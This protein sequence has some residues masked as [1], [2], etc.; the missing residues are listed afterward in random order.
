MCKSKEFPNDS[1]SDKGK[2]YCLGW[3]QVKTLIWK[4][5]LSKFRTPLGT[6]FEIFS[7]LMLI[8]V[9]VVS[10]QL[11]EVSTRAAAKYSSIDIEFPGPWVDLVGAVTD[12]LGENGTADIDF[13]EILGSRRH[14]SQNPIQALQGFSILQ[15]IKPHVQKHRRRLQASNNNVTEDFGAKEDGRD[16]GVFDFLDVAADQIQDV[17]KNPFP[18]PTFDQYVLASQAISSLINPDDLPIILSQSSFGR[19]FGNLLTLGTLHISPDVDIAHEFVEYL[20]KT[21]PSVMNAL[22]V[23]LHDSEESAVSFINDNLNERTW[24]L[25]DF[26]KFQTLEDIEFQIRMNYTTLPNTNR[27]VNYVARGLNTRYRRY[28]LSGYLTLQRTIDEFA[29]SRVGCDDV[30]SNIWSMPMP[31]AKFEQNVFF[32]AVGF[33]LGLTIAMAFLYPTSRTIKMIVEEKES[34]MKETLLILG[35]RPWA[36]WLS[37]F[38]SSNFTYLIS[39]MLVTWALTTSILVNSNAVYLYVFIGFFSTATVGFCFVVAACFSRAKLA[40]I[41]GPMAFFAT[42]LPRFIFFDSNRYEATGGKLLGSLL[43]CTAF[44]FGADIIADYEYAEVGIQSW[45]ASEGEYSFNTA[46]FMLFFDTFLYTFLGWYLD[47]VI[48]RQYGV[49]RP[50]Y[51][52][53]LPSYWCS[54][55]SCGM[56]TRASSNPTIAVKANHGSLSDQTDFEPVT[57]DAL[58]PTVFI[59]SLVKKYSKAANRA[60]DDLTLTLYESQITCLLGHNGAGKT[61]T[62]SILTG[63]FPPTSGDCVVYGNS[64]VR[65]PNSIR[66]SMGICPQHNVLFDRLSVNEHLY[67]FQRIKGANPTS[68]DVT[69]SAVEVGLGEYHKTA[70]MALSGGNKRKLSLAIALSGDPKLLLLDEP[71]SGMDVASRRHCWELL[72]R[73]RKGRVTLLTTH[74]LDEAS[75]LADRIAVMKE[76]KLQCCGSE[77]FLKSRFGLGYN[78]TIVMDSDKFTTVRSRDNVDAVLTFLTA[79]VVGTKLIRESARELTFR[80]P[81]GAEAQFPEMF[82]RLAV[83]SARLGIGSYGISDTTLEEIF[84]QLADHEVSDIVANEATP[85]DDLSQKTEDVHRMLNGQKS[86]EGTSANASSITK[87][88]QSLEISKKT[89]ELNAD[90]EVSNEELQH[91]SPLRQIVLLY[92]KRFLIQRRDVKGFFFS[93]ILPVILCAL[94]LLILIIEIPIVGPPREISMGLYSSSAGTTN[95]LTDVVIGGGVSFDETSTSRMAS[96]EQEFD[97]LS[98]FSDQYPNARIVHLENASS[99]EDLS[100]HL[101]DTYND[102]DHH[103]RYGSFVLFDRINFNIDVNWT[104]L[105][106]E[107]RTLMDL[108]QDSVGWDLFRGFISGVFGVNS[109][110]V[111]DLTDILGDANKSLIDFNISVL[112]DF[113]LSTFD[114]MLFYEKT[115]EVLTSIGQASIPSNPN[116]GTDTVANFRVAIQKFVNEA[117]FVDEGYQ[118][119]Q[120][121][122]AAFINDI[123]LIVTRGVI[124]DIENVT[125]KDIAEILLAQEEIFNRSLIVTGM[126]DIFDVLLAPFGGA[127]VTSKAVVDLVVGALDETVSALLGNNMSSSPNDFLIL[128]IVMLDEL[129]I[130]LV[131]NAEYYGNSSFGYYGNS[132]FGYY[133]NSS[134]L[135]LFN[136]LV[137][138]LS[139]LYLS[140]KVDDITL[141]LQLLSASA[142]GLSLEIAL[143]NF[144]MNARIEN[145]TLNLPSMTLSLSGMFLQMMSEQL[146]EDGN[147]IFELGGSFIES[148]LPAQPITYTVGIDS[149]TSIIHNSSSPHAVA[150]FNQA[151]ME[152]LFKRCTGDPVSSRLVSINNPLPITNEQAIEVQTILSILAGLFLLIPYC[153]IPG[154]FVVFLVKERVSK[155][156]HL[157]LVSG[158]DLTSYWVSTYLWDM[159][160]FAVITGLL[161]LVFF[162]Y[163]SKSAV[164]FVGNAQSAIA[165]AALTFGYGLSILPFSYLLSRMFN[166]HSSAQIAIMA[167]VFICG[168]VAVNGYYIMT[169]IEETQ[170]LAATLLPIFRCFPSFNV[171]E[172]FI[173]LSQAYFERLILGIEKSPLDWDVAGLPLLLL[174]SEPIPYFLILLFLEYSADGGS[175]GFVGRVIRKI[176]T[177]YTNLI[178]SCYGIR[179][180]AEGISLVLEDS[181]DEGRQE[182]EDVTNE[183]S[184]VRENKTELIGKAS[185]LIY[186]MWKVF[187]PSVGFLGRFIGRICD[188]LCCRCFGK[189]RNKSDDDEIDKSNFPK[190]AVRGVCTAVMPG[191]TYGLLGVNGAGKTTTLGVL[192]GDLSPTSGEAYVAGNDITGVTPGG[193]AAARKNIGFCPQVDP[194]LDLM[195][196]RETL[197]LFGRLRGIQENKLES[198]V[199]MLL[200]HLTLTPHAE[201]TSQSYS[202]GNKRKLSLGIALI[203]DPKVLFIDEASSGM[204]PSARRKTWKLIEQAA[205]TRSVVITSHSMEEVEALCTR[206]SIMVKGQ[207]LCLGSVQHL[208]SK[209]LDGYIVEVQCE[210]GTPDAIVDGMVAKIR[211]ETLPGSTLYERHGRF[212]SFETSSASSISLAAAFRGLQELKE[213]NEIANYS[214]SQSSLER[215]FIKLVNNEQ[216]P[217][218]TE[219]IEENARDNMREAKSLFIAQGGGQY[220]VG[221]PIGNDQAVLDSDEYSV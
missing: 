100:E 168:F 217:A 56:A 47:L 130:A 61:T 173:R 155:S 156:K 46:I 186:D 154:A 140:V 215:V 188:I 221:K 95:E 153:Y 121:A 180:D 172:G 198:V 208:K 151:Y 14:L 104:A 135:E 152:N 167:I 32:T 87:D 139:D 111:I 9:L 88:M 175:G 157:Q 120:A 102:K 131:G 59:Q 123:A 124:V 51:F 71:T 190:R 93:V 29:M 171:G 19:S 119:I 84:L 178:L 11:S 16:D 101:L 57:D 202:G 73:K 80:F 105:L 181:L 13:G 187:P 161:M 3:T 216:V 25:V 52:L 162:L 219:G 204:D 170:D 177:A 99:S 31:T 50:W 220:E 39:A 94:I 182:D 213:S 2:N 81:R 115:Q 86:S 150:A 23:R 214:I 206:V 55:L 149:R 90:L 76:G 164:V 5:F 33:L 129:G 1:P 83:E 44:A 114:P 148:L 118:D 37:W 70:S 197:R 132:S 203:G 117:N 53:F 10:F 218:I 142:Q 165:S 82:D 211:T 158:V 145:A 63:L 138:F 107:L 64:I 125:D 12:L 163:G 54:I 40:A 6:F 77:L 97:Y 69:S 199:S 112:Q 108:D 194:L 26:T 43:P 207:F 85:S 196:G 110:S 174:Y 179:K 18:V 127:N 45:N 116:F 176:R 98:S 34:R 201:K 96:L 75:L 74:F 67:F 79:I 205:Q 141:D 191:E 212:L 183:R 122:A 91:L 92:M 62:I 209:Y 8:M 133:E 184:F 78:L 159:T 15:E 169:T 193:V 109:T 48:P 189:H 210:G 113:N 89:T 7:P 66:Q 58:T 166:N 72:R 185:I 147:V 49:A 38:L 134:I 200:E 195:T 36:H 4:T 192:T 41:V 144:Q 146:L 143:P 28:Y 103:E 20:N 65:D 68:D 42:L 35:V 128:P 27:I 126:Y 21:F 24:A 136:S 106:S 160:L 17:L 137:E 22:K 30:N 60:V